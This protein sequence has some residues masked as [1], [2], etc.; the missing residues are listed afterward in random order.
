[1]TRDETD[2]ERKALNIM[3]EHYGGKRKTCV[4]SFYTER[5]SLHRSFNESIT[6]YIIRAGMAITVLRNAEETLSDGL[7][8]AI[9]LNVLPESINIVQSDN[10]N[11]A[12]FELTSSKL[13]SYSCSQ[14]EH[15]AHWCTAGHTEKRQ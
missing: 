15:K 2:D 3:K 6:E 9:I 10:D 1:M 8:I 5:M 12:N 7:L 11:F 13:T 4:I 14:K